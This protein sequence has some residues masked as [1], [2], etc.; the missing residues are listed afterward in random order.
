MI[1]QYKLRIS[2]DIYKASIIT[3]FVALSDE[4][5]DFDP[6]NRDLIILKFDFFFKSMRRFL[7]HRTS[8]YH[9]SKYAGV[10]VLPVKPVKQAFPR[11]SIMP[12]LT[13]LTGRNEKKD[14]GNAVDAKGVRT[15]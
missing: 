13:L 2:L 3:V 8:D 9:I 10:C 5:L 15:E 4:E 12:Q 11:R 1:R 7:Y 14:E 6:R